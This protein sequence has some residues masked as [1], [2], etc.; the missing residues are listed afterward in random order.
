M[1]MPA[2]DSRLV[3]LVD[4]V[5]DN[6]R[7]LSEALDLAGYTVLVATDG[8]S[9]LE[10]LDY[11][12]PDIILL[13][14]V[15]PG[16]DGFETCRRLKAHRG[17]GHVPVV[18]MTGLVEAE[19]VVRGFQAGGSDYVTKPIDTDAVLARIEA[20]MR[21]ARM[22][23]AAI[24]VIDAVAHA[25]V[26]LDTRGR[27]LWETRRA[28]Q[29]LR[30]YFGEAQTSALPAP[31]AAWAG[32]G[33]TALQGGA[34]PLPLTVSGSGRLEIRLAPAQ[35]A[36]EYILLFEEQI[37]TD[38]AGALG[39]EFRLTPREVDVLLWVARGKTNRDISDILGMSPRT[40]NKHLEHIFVKLGVETRAAA[41]ALTVRVLGTLPPAH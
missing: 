10:R 37:G 19:D 22:M 15:M 20:H 32:Q 26:V 5:P 41:T 18:F 9:A 14:A 33:L 30:E 25:V 40:V 28:R 27:V 13:D 29:W 35:R 8:P 2:N 38:P 1:P 4:D 3:L 11:V 24:D 23:S 12:T 21:S 39:C 6:L 16:M 7:L 36:G 34:T 31:L 17:A